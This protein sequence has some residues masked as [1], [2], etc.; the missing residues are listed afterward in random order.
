M[1]K[2]K[3]IKQPIVESK[4]EPLITAGI[5]KHIAYLIGLSLLA[6]LCIVLLTVGVIGVGMDM[7]AISYYRENALTIFSD[8]VLYKDYYYEYPILLFIPVFIAMIPSVI[9]NNSIAAYMLSFSILMIACDTVTVV[10]IYLIARKIWNNSRTAFIAAM[11]YMTGLAVQ[12]FAMIDYSSVAVMLM[13]IGL[14]ILFYGKEKVTKYSW[15]TDNLFT[16]LGYFMKFFPLLISPFILLYKS[17]ATSLKY[18]ITSFLKLAIPFAIVLIGPTLLLNPWATI[19]TYVPLRLDAGTPSGYF[20]NTII[21]SLYVWLHDIF[22]L[23]V[24]MDHV[25][26]FIYACM[27]TILCALLYAAYKYDKQD[28]T[29]LLKFALCALVVI[30]LAYKARSPGYIMW[31]LPF[32]CILIA[33]N[34]YKICW[35]Y[36]TQILTYLVFP[37]SFWLLW[38]NAGW[39]NPMYSANWYLALILLSAESLS[40]IVLTWLAIEPIKMYKE[41][42][43]KN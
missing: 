29:M 23:A 40:L 17:K 34:I 13:M 18:E 26:I 11:V 16:I 14:T 21:W 43:N 35:F 31:F 12:Y 42:F 36:V 4:D 38:T 32:A 5:K 15:M 9:L 1:S 24:T 6:K 28:P 39:T 2:K 33:N 22:K 10:C 7:Y 27:I 41:I 8:H 19:K 20:P 25:F 37:L 3:Q 30:V